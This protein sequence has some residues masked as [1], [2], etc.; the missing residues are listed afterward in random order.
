MNLLTQ[1]PKN[2]RAS[3][4]SSQNWIQ[5]KNISVKRTSG[6]RRYYL[7][8]LK[9]IDAF[10]Q[11]L[12]QTGESITDLIRSSNYLWRNGD[13]RDTE[14]TSYDY[15]EQREKCPTLKQKL[16]SIMTYFFPTSGTT[17]S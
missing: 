12:P 16:S 15:A 13:P 10:E 2:T 5:I 11:G 1:L 7:K 8:I 17:N 14:E 9:E 6:S 4:M 3:Y